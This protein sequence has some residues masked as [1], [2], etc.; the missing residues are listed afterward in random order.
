VMYPCTT[1]YEIV[2]YY[3]DG[4][5]FDIA[6]NPVNLAGVESVDSDNSDTQNDENEWHH[7]I[8]R[9]CSLHCLYF[10]SS[11]NIACDLRSFMSIVH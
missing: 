1:G 9:D 10:P 5:H 11:Y 6:V 7:I 8:C 3:D 2:Y 4:A